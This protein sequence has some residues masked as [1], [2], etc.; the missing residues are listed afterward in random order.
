VSCFG[1]GVLFIMLPMLQATGA[2]RA[3]SVLAVRHWQPFPCAVRALER[4][5]GARGRAATGDLKVL[6]IRSYAVGTL[7]ATAFYAGF[8]SIFLVLSL[9]LQQGLKFRRCMRH[10]PR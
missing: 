7:T 4:R 9:F 3:A 10:C 2:K 5:L 1:L 8:T 6:R